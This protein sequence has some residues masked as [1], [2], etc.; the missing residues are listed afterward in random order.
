MMK[1]YIIEMICDDTIQIFV[2]KSK[3]DVEQIK[4]TIFRMYDRCDTLNIYLYDN[5]TM[6]DLRQHYFVDNDF[7]V[8]QNIN[9]MLKKYKLIY[10]HI[11]LN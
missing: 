9:C 10:A 7:N 11:I 2:L 3:M 1:N 8:L 6:Y 4:E 5:K